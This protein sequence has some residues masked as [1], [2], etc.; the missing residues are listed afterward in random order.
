MKREIDLNGFQGQLSFRQPFVAHHDG[1]ALYGFTEVFLLGGI[2]GSDR[3]LWSSLIGIIRG[4]SIIFKMILL[5]I[6]EETPEDEGPL[7]LVFRI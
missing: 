5:E 2:Q 1:Q 7:P 3:D 4:V 6:L